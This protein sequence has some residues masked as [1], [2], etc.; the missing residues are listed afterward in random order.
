[1]QNFDTVLDVQ[2]VSRMVIQESVVVKPR[3][4]GPSSPSRTHLLTEDWSWRELRDYVVAEVE[5][6]QGSVDIDPVKL[7]AIFKGFVHRQPNA[8]AIARYAFETLDGYWQ[9]RPVDVYRFCKANDPFF[10]RPISEQIGSAA[11]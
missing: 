6:R 1:M 2:G 10:A 5:K 11:Q 8:Q 4:A 7:A 3:A 9:N